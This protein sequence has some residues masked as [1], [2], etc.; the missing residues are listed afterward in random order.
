MDT[1]LTPN[2]SDAITGR[3][4]MVLSRGNTSH[5]VGEFVCD[6]A[7]REAVSRAAGGLKGGDGREGWKGALR[8]R[9]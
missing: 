4:C 3:A 8:I 9:N 7:D 1:F 2:V 5:P 6:Y